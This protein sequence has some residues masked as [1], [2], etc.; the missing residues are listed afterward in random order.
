MGTFIVRGHMINLVFISLF[1]VLTLIQRF[2]LRRENY[3]KQQEKSKTTQEE[4]Q[5]ILEND[6]RVGDESVNFVYRL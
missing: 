5:D 3:L 2:L 4:L 6:S 1:I